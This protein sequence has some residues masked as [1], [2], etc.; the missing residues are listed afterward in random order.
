LCPSALIAIQPG[1]LHESPDGFQPAQS[2]VYNKRW[3]A[4]VA[5]DALIQGNDTP[6][7]LLSYCKIISANAV[8]LATSYIY[9][10]IVPGEYSKNQPI[11]Y[12]DLTSGQNVHMH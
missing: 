8:C 7:Q 10:L 11:Q 5:T 1:S 12:G 6:D 2:N 3:L 4:V 9:T